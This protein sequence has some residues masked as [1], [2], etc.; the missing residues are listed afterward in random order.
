MLNFLTPFFRKRKRKLQSKNTSL[1]SEE[2]SIS[3]WQDT[4]KVYYLENTLKLSYES[5]L[6]KVTIEDLNLD[7]LRGVLEQISNKD[8]SL[9]NQKAVAN[10]QDALT[11]RIC[12]VT[13]QK[14]DITKV[15]MSAKNSIKT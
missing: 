9:Q 13:W 11:I 6:G 7:K 4:G 12:A 14:K 1:N 10:V 2:R 15:Y 3:I 5:D 8:R